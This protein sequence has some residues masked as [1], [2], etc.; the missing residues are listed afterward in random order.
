MPKLRRCHPRSFAFNLGKPIPRLKLARLPPLLAASRAALPSI[1]EIPFLDS[2]FPERLP[3]FCFLIETHSLPNAHSLLP[4]QLYVLCSSSRSL[5]SYFLILTSFI[6]STV[7]YFL[8]TD[9]IR[10]EFNA[11]VALGNVKCL[12]RGA[13]LRP[14]DATPLPLPQS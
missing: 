10:S 2:C 8:L 3:S 13:A 4:S 12:G 6:G 5:H 14:L 9:S 11:V 1:S 7:G